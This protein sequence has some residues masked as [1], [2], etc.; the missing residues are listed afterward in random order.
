MS[1]FDADTFLDQ[2]VEGANSTQRLT[3]DEG[4]YDGIVDSLQV[5][6][7]EKDG[8]PWARLAIMWSIIDQG[9]LDTLKRDKAIVRQEFFLDL[10]DNGQIDMSEGRNVA[11]GKVRK[12]TGTNE[13]RFNLRM[14]EGRGAKV[15][16]VKTVDKAGDPRNDVRSVAAA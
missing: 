16:V 10:D 8:R 5:T 6:P 4:V 14:L 1:A 9:V 13:G 15:H 7:G 2:E 3:C 12:A 11:L